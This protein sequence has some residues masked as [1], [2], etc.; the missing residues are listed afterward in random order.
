MTF[1]ISHA[2]LAAFKARLLAAK[3]KAQGIGELAGKACR[4]RAVLGGALL[5]RIA[6]SI[7]LQQEPS[8][9]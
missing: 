8:F 3:M 6:P 4:H 2:R 5:L 7:G 9:T 1:L